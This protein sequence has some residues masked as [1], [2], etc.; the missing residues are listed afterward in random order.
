MSPKHHQFQIEILNESVVIDTFFLYTFLRK[1]VTPFNKTEAFKLGL[2]DERGKVL[3]K[4]SQLSSSEE[5]R[6]FTMFDVLIWNIK[7]LLERLPF[8]RSRLASYAAALWLLKESEFHKYY[9]EDS[10]LLSESFLAFC[11][12]LH[13][14]FSSR[15]TIIKLYESVESS[16]PE[17]KML[18]ET[19]V[20]NV[21][22]GNIA[23][24]TLDTQPVILK[25]KK[26]LKRKDLDVKE[27][28]ED[29][30]TK[31]NFKEFRK[32]RNSRK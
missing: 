26:I 30:D 12:A 11:H 23:G 27:T 13:L 19:P 29:A 4:R 3:K 7:K 10:E 16:I 24:T 17:F 20:N 2:I 15:S 21:G 9:A 5:K 31:L 32:R 1:L 25:K 22:D 8:G 14:D 28:T 18:T 6:A